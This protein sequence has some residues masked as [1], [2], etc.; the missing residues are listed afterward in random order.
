MTALKNYAFPPPGHEGIESRGI[1]VLFLRTLALDGEGGQLHAPAAL[2]SFTRFK[3]D[4]S[5]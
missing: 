4:I 5:S 1:I 2:P 3:I